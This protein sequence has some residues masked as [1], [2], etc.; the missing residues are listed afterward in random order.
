[1]NSVLAACDVCHACVQREAQIQFNV[2]NNQ[3]TGIMDTVRLAQAGSKASNMC[4]R[5]QPW[6]TA[7]QQQQCHAAYGTSAPSGSKESFATAATS[8]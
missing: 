3:T 5:Q 1:M 7:M 4:L 8:K 2:S 6:H